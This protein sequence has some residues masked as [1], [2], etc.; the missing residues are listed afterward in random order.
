[1]ERVSGS[2]FSERPNGVVAV[3]YNICMG[4]EHMLTAYF[5]FSLELL[6]VNYRENKDIFIILIKNNKNN[7]NVFSL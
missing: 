5:Y 1:M 3:V 4:C 7:H 6:V 2:L